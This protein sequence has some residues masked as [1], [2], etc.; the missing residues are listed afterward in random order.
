MQAIVHSHKSI[1]SQMLREIGARGGEPP[2]A[3][4]FLASGS[5]AKAL[6]MQQAG[7]CTALSQQL[8]EGSRRRPVSRPVRE[9]SMLLNDNGLASSSQHC[10][11]CPRSL[12]TE[13]KRI[14]ICNRHSCC[15]L[16]FV[17]QEIEERVSHRL[18]KCF[19]TELHPSPE[20]HLPLGFL[21][22]GCQLLCL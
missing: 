14:I 13:L 18:V 10:L 22:T 15:L 8:W 20:P 9:D 16:Y 19:M 7:Q 11:L 6:S 3:S 17:V 5:E 12:L 2:K 21:G 1:Y 4:F